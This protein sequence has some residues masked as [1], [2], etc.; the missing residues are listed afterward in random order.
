M[1]KLL[2]YV[3]LHFLVC[4]IL[5][6]L[7]NHYFSII[8]INIVT[9]FVSIC[10]FTI[11]LFFF[12]NRKF[13]TLCSLLL[14][15]SIGVFSSFIN[16]DKNASTYFEKYAT[17]NQT[18]IL[19]IKKKLKSTAYYNKFEATL[20]QVNN[21]KTIGKI[22]VNIKKDSLQKQI[23]IDD[24]IVTKSSLV[25]ILKPKNPN[26]FSYKNYLAHQQ[27]YKQVFLTD[28]Q[29]LIKRDDKFSLARIV[30]NSKNAIKGSLNNYSFSKDE[31]SILYAL[32]L[33]EKQLISQELKAN[34]SKAGVIHILAISGLHV[35]ILV[36][37]FLFLLKPIEYLKNGVTYKLLIT[38]IL[39]WNF[40]IFTGLSASV[41]RAV[42]MYSFVAIGQL[43]NRKTPIYFSLI[44]SMLVLLLIK[45]LFLFDVGFQLSYCAVFSIVW[46]Q[47]TLRKLYKPKYKIVKYFWDLI[48]VS[49]AAQ[50]GVLP[51]SIFYFNQVPGLFLVANLVVIPTLF[52]V[53]ILGIA[54]IISSLF[55]SLPEL[56]I[57]LF[58]WLISS[59]NSFVN[60][61]ANQ[62]VFLLKKLYI[63]SFLMLCIYAIIIAS[64]LIIKKRTIKRFVFLLFGII[65]FQF[66]FILE[67]HQ[68]N[69]TRELLVFYKPKT[70]IVVKRNG[71][72]LVSNKNAAFL[73]EDYATKS[74]IESEKI[75]KI[76]AIDFKNIFAIDKQPVLL[77]D[78]LGIYNVTG[79]E[80]PIV[81][82][83]HSP[84]INVQRMIK[85]LQPQLIIAD[86]S[87]YKNYVNQWQEIAK[88]QKTPFYNV[89]E[90]GAFMYKF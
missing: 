66:V 40:A 51:L 33:G 60:W 76:D 46:I 11:V 41:V 61:V 31:L 15:F 48:T 67:K 16:N 53:L 29:F 89:F 44:T 85:T 14:F 56:F 17:K 26:Q 10:T 43:I 12:K 64:I 82:L 19:Q 6:V 80:K 62:E 5:G 8:N 72:R 22:L 4:Y 21:I 58:S 59:L 42:T 54:T 88:K 78:S 27:I 1:R 38:I 39:L 23:H 75:T 52:L 32:F 36:I 79:L 63:S 55:F 49:T 77:I 74:Y 69:T 28:N 86:A 37:I 13:I 70:S 30:E 65:S 20:I 24:K 83:Q 73:K 18:S 35:G 25:T 3:P 87:N 71:N 57:R 2:Q 90:K 84:K 68:K 34:Y 47:P 81:I 7:L 45:P 50:L 9:F